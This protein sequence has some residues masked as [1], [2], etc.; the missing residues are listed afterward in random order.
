MFVSRKK[1]QK[2]E[3]RLE[4]LEQQVFE[5]VKHH[6]WAIFSP[7]YVPT[8]KGKLDAVIRQQRLEVSVRHEKLEPIA[9]KK[10]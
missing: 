3:Q 9:R 6:K 5:D 10:R 1:Y 7:E 4:K 8:L 2:L